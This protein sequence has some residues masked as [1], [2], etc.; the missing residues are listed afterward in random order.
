MQEMLALMQKM[1]AL[2]KCKKCQPG[3]KL[4]QHCAQQGQKKQDRSSS[5]AGW[6]LDQ[7][8]PGGT[9]C[10]CPGRLSAYWGP[11]C[12]WA[13]AWKDSE[14]EDH[15]VWRWTAD[16]KYTT[17]SSYKMY[18]RGLS[19]SKAPNSSGKQGPLEKLN[20]FSGQQPAGEDCG[21]DA[22]SWFGILHYL[23]HVQQRRRDMWPHSGHMF[24]FTASLVSAPLLPR[25]HL[26]F[27]S[28]TSGD[29]S[30]LP[31]MLHSNHRRSASAKRKG[32]DTL[33]A[34]TVW[35]LWKQR[36]NACVFA[37]KHP[38]CKTL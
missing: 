12:L 6:P 9:F 19:L 5:T 1:L 16:G 30:L 37:E 4:N 33:F 26:H 20:C 8:H 21:S 3:T 32:F 17:Q 22:P 34:L 23:L 10:R 24:L 13:T 18:I 15:F 31:T 35:T 25:G 38:H 7:G 28:G 27:C 29:R 2:K 11:D 36:N 14:S